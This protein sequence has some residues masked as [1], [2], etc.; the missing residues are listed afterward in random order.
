MGDHWKLNSPSLL[1]VVAP[2]AKAMKLVRVVMVMVTPAC[3]IVSPNRS[4]S[5]NAPPGPDSTL[6]N[7]C[8]VTNMLSTPELR[9]TRALL[10]D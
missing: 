8:V 6:R 3:F 1:T 5:G 9:Q 2:M 7:D 4:S 10:W